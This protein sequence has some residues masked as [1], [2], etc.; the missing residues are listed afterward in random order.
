ME[1]RGEGRRSYIAAS[2]VHN[3]RLN[4]Y[5]EIFRITCVASIIIFFKLWKLK[6][7]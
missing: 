5:G 1:L 3:K 2:S 7:S 6:V 4:A